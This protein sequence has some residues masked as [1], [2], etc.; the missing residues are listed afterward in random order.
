MIAMQDK[1]QRPMPMLRTA[2]ALASLL[3][4]GLFGRRVTL[5]WV[6]EQAAGL[7]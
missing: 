5:P 4:L 1:V 6:E 7:Q 3:G 2:L